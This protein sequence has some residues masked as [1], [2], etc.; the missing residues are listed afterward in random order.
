MRALASGAP[1]RLHVVVQP[2]PRGMGDA[3]LQCAPLLEGALGGRPILI[4]QTHDLVE[5]SLFRALVE[6]LSADDADGFVV[7]V[8]L[9]SYFPGGYLVV[10]DGRAVDVIETPPPGSEPSDLMKIVDDLIRCPADLL[11]A[12]GEVDPNPADHYERALGRLMAG[13]TIR[14]VDYPGPWVPI[15]YPWDV[16]RAADL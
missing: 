10:E 9:T 16:L 15:K 11:R 6:R 5:P 1:T 14:V 3:V 4:T 7:G 13:G 8:R 12:L 2:E